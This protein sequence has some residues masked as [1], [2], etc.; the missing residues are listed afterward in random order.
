MVEEF[1][2]RDGQGISVY[3]ILRIGRRVVVAIRIHISK[4]DSRIA[5]DCAYAVGVT[6][7]V[8][9]VQGHGCVMEVEQQRFMYVCHHHD[10]WLRGYNHRE[11]TDCTT[12]HS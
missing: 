9:V 1:S 10:L 5:F 6:D 12:P 4:L 11:I 2:E 3:R 8:C 7:K